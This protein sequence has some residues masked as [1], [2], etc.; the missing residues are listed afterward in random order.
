MGDFMF[1]GRTAE[2]KSLEQA[3]ESGKFQMAVI[4]G[5]RRVGKTSLIREFVKGKRALFF[6]AQEQ[7]DADNIADFSREIAKF[8]GLPSDMRF[9]GWRAAIDYLCD[10][11][12]RERFILVIDE[13]PYAAKRFPT[14]PSLLQVAI[15]HRLQETNAFLILCGS[16]QGFMESDVLGYKSPLYGR[17]TL[18]VKLKP[19]GYREAADMLPSMSPDECFKTYACIGGVPYYLA[20]VQE[21]KSLRDNLSQLYFRPPGFLYSEPELLLRQEL[22]EPAVYYSVLRAVA[23][24]ATRPKAIAE[25]AGVERNSIAGY[26][27]TL[28]DLD[29]LERVVPFGDN[30]DRSKR[31]VYRIREPMFDFWFTFVSP[32]VAMIDANAGDAVIDS[33]SE[34]VF[35][36]YLGH[37]FER[38]CREW[39]VSQA[40]SGRFVTPIATV[41]SWWGTDPAAREQVDIDVLAAD[42]SGKRLL[43]GECKYRS[44]FDETEALRTLEH[45]ASL[46]KDCV[47]EELVL[48]SKH[49]VSA[50]TR[51]KVDADGRLHAVCLDEMYE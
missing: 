40:L 31:A 33:I 22:A 23:S 24:G 7:S 39:T 15:D 6:T 34:E 48:F 42:A 30:P 28:V 11:A 44:S 21:G 12:E 38:V 1:V 37:W 25:R 14:F 13:F 49:P 51:E 9:G 45:R 16:N 46:I 2:L 43:A 50:G 27:S 5:R 20:Q 32:N 10:Q 18:Q 29:I 17:R 35:A 8:F 3:F 4:Y 36:T 19:F 41:G 26:I 47:T